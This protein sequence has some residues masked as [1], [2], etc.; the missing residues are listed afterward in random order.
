VT[1][2]YDAIIVGG[3]HNG[4]VAAAYLARAGRKVLV[5]ER[6]AMVGGAAV[7]EEFP[8]A[9]GFKF[10]SL[11]D[12]PGGLLPRIVRDLRLREHGFEIVCAP[13]APALFAPQPD[14]RG[15]S[16]WPDPAR[17]ASEIARFSQR[18]AERFPEF[19]RLVGK[20]AGLVAAL[21]TTI[22]PR[23]PDPSRSD[24]LE[25]L[26]LAGPARSLGRRDLHSLLRVLPMPVADLLDE[27]FE[28]ESLRGALAARGVT[29]IHWGPR[30]AGTAYVLLYAAAISAN[31]L[32]A[33]GAVKGGMGGLTQALAQAAQALG[34]EI[35]ASAAVERI[36]VKDGRTTGVVLADGAELTAATVV[37]NADPRTTFFQLVDPQHLD[38]EF[39][40][41]AGN[42]KYRGCGARVH[43]ALSDL[44]RFTAL[45]GA[46]PAAHLAGAIMIAP[47][48]DY[49]ER[50]YDAAKYGGYA[51]QPMIE[52]RLPSLL[53]PSLAPPG[54]HTLS[55][56]AQYAPYRLKNG[57][58][59]AERERL[60]DAV[61]DTLTDYAPNLKSVILARKV[62]TPL[63]LETGYGLPEGNA[64]HGEMTLDQFLHMR[65]VPGWAQYRAPIAGLYLCG[66]G[67]HPGGGVTGA[68]GYNAARV[69]LQNKV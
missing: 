32:L 25:L 12:G 1:N 21:M 64:N 22:P 36:R 17:A 23:L 56:Y 47:G 19:L 55:V 31:R 29:G 14:G 62:L 58:W 28:S 33:D 7:T 46:D 42:I 18:D 34:A 38:P 61:V 43:L 54:G 57:N 26:R 27:W 10:S 49:L 48:I 60:G 20:L 35:R 59:E 37:S 39:L 4:L 44:P 15:L 30:A 40:W 24:W 45:N 8:E 68:N 52:A 16:L 67:T 2:P 66:A 69:I 13:R 5:L 6:R 3:G 65:P 41:H 9:P 11:A 53:D 51:R 50:A 63:D